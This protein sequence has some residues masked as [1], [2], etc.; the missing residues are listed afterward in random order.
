MSW[1]SLVKIAVFVTTGDLQIAEVRHQFNCG[2]V[3]W[4]AQTSK[5]QAECRFEAQSIMYH[6]DSSFRNAFIALAMT[7]SS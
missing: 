3:T 2:D 6:L 7:K 5:W 1:G 4:D